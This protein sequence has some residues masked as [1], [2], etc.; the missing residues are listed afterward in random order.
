VRF[1]AK[2]GAIRMSGKVHRPVL[3]SP[4]T[5]KALAC[6]WLAARNG[7]GAA[8]LD[9]HELWLQYYLREGRTM[10][11][12]GVVIGILVGAALTPAMALVV[13]KDQVCVEQCRRD[14]RATGGR[15]GMSKRSEASRVQ[16]C[17]QQCAPARQQQRR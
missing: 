10:Q 14:V 12:I 9:P 6:D 4:I 3:A 11:L 13:K 8:M 5:T 16:A 17:I 7:D 1:A 15:G 2:S